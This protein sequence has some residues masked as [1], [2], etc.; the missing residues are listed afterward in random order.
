MSK[1]TNLIKDAEEN[2]LIW[3]R[4]VLDGAWEQHGRTRVQAVML[5]E[6]RDQLLH[7]MQENGSK[8]T[9]EKELEETERELNQ[10]QGSYTVKNPGHYKKLKDNID[11][12]K[13]ARDYWLG[14][15]GEL[16]T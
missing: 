12:H 15:M 14:R 2:Y 1:I 10:V 4:I 9:F 16:T 8:D 3:E 6:K 13:N 11:E 5:R 7:W